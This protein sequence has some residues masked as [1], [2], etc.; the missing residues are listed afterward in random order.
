M[1][2][3]PS[4]FRAQADAANRQYFY[5]A[6]RLRLPIRFPAAPDT[7]ADDHCSPADWALSTHFS[8]PS[9]VAQ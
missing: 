6:G 4:S 1:F 8:D 5:G 2:T 9:R 7:S 3:I